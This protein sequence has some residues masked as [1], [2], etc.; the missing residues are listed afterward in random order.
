MIWKF[1]GGFLGTLAAK[2]LAFFA[3]YR[4]GEKAQQ[5]EDIKAAHQ[6][7]I[8]AR[9]IEAKVSVESDDDLDHDLERRMYRSKPNP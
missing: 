5:A 6:E 3:I 8:D 4:S 9:Q 2:I 7:D 1:L